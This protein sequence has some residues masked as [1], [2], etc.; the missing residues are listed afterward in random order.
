M[1]SAVASTSAVVSNAQT[2]KQSFVVT[3]GDSRTPVRTL[4]Y[5]VNPIDL[6]V[7]TLDSN[8]LFAMFE[9]TSYIKG[10]PP[11]HV[12]V[13]QDEIYFLLEG[14]FTF[15][16]HDKLVKVKSGDTVFCPRGSAHTFAQQSDSGRLLLMH[17]PPGN[18]EE[19]F[20]A[21]SKL[22]QP[23]S[24]EAGAKLFA[25]HGMKIVGPPIE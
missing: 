24:P 5:G 15:K 11:L 2:P 7:S 25:A 17:L 6:K 22:T 12:N 16:L 3:R 19:Y 10:G 1:A 21:L 13:N 4:V 18:I 20:N 8:G 14:E 23:P 9:Y